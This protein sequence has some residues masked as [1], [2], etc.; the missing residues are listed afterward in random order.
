MFVNSFSPQ[1]FKTR[2]FQRSLVLQVSQSI[3]MTH[4]EGDKISL[5]QSI[6]NK[7]EFMLY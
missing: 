6:L 7:I 3:H 5:A 1:S 2:K 4:R